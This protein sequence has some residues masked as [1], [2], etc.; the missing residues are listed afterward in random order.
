MRCFEDCLIH[1]S[2]TE[3]KPVLD[4][5]DLWSV[6]IGSRHAALN[7]KELISQEDMISE[8]GLKTKP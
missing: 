5:I 7:M 3:E 2:G 4:S 8:E 6:C 1:C